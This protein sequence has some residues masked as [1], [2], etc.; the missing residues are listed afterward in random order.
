M[1]K[2]LNV[3]RWQ[4][5]W[6]SRKRRFRFWCV[7]CSG[8][9]QAFDSRLGLR[10]RTRGGPQLRWGWRT[11]GH[12]LIFCFFT[13]NAN[14]QICQHQITA[15][16]SQIDT[17]APLVISQLLL[18]HEDFGLELV[19]LVEDVPQLLQGEAGSVGV[20]RVR[21]APRL[22]VAQGLLPQREEGMMKRQ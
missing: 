22:L 2:M 8:D 9:S 1:L 6:S 3:R 7:T 16:A 10:Q 13:A 4:R 21:A 17:Q 19:P 12:D 11:G 20:L 18:Q 5:M 15:S 14:N